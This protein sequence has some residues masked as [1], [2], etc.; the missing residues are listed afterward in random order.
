MKIL[1]YFRSWLEE[2]REELDV[3]VFDVDGVLLL[4]R[5]PAPGAVELLGRLSERGLPFRILTNDGNHSIDE[6]AALLAAAGLVVAPGAITSSGHG[7]VEV[8]RQAGLAGERCFV[9]G[10]LGDPCYA[11]LAGLRVTRRL[12]ELA[13]CRAVIVG[14]DEY[15]W[16]PAVNGV[17]NFLISHPEAPLIVPNPDLYYPTENRRIHV[18]AGGVA[19]L[20]T[21]VC[22]AF[23]RP[24]EPVFLGKPYAPIFLHNHHRLEQ[25]FGRPVERRRVLMV[26]DSLGSDIAGAAGFG[27]RAALVL[28]GATAEARFESSAIEPELVFRGL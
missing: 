3:L 10:R 26:G 16:E 8:A 11:E 22:G 7:L 24:V 27:Y 6:K 13:A 20:V 15:D 1:D 21:A 12:E 18:S 9:M 5:R 14:E 25:A 4:G 28:T 23:G 19:G 2:H 17:I